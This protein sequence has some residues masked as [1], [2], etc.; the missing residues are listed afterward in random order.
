LKA[1]LAHRSSPEETFLTFARRHDGAT[2]RQLAD[3]EVSS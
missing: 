1:Y 3:A 2:L